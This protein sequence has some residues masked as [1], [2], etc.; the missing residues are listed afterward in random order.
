MNSGSVNKRAKGWSPAFWHCCRGMWAAREGRGLRGRR[1][2]GPALHPFPSL[3]HSSGL[4]S[5]FLSPT[6]WPLGQEESEQ[7]AG[8]KWGPHLT[9]QRW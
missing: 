6:Q 9:Q 2:G 4:P 3:S 5:S 7:G 1:F 8:G